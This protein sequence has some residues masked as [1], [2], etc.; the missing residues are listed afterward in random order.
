MMSV[1]QT[2]EDAPLG[3]GDC[4]ENWRGVASSLALLGLAL[5]LPLLNGWKPLQGDEDAYYTFAAHIA[6]QPTDPYGFRFPGDVPANHLLAPPVVL[7]WWALAIRVVGMQPVL[8]K[9]WLI[10]FSLL[11]VFSLHALFRR[12]CRGLEMPLVWFTALSPTL[13]PNFTLMLDVPALALSLAAVSL[14]L[15]AVERGSVSLALVA[16]LL[17]GV[18]ME[19]KYT[20]FVTPVVL[21]LAGLLFRR[22]R[23][24]V[25]AAGLA[26]ALF[27]GWE[28]LTAVRYGESHFLHSL[29]GQSRSL[30]RPLHLLLPLLTMLGGVAPM[31]GL[32]GL[33]GL[34]QSWRV[35]LAGIGVVVCAYLLLVLLRN[36][37]AAGSAG[38]E[39]HRLPIPLVNIGFGVLGITIC[40]VTVL[41][42]CQLLFGACPPKPVDGSGRLDWFIV[43]WL[44]LELAS[45][46]ALTPLPGVRRLLGTVVVATLLAG[47]PVARPGCV[48][49][50]RSLVYGIALANVVLALG[51][52]A[53]EV[54]DARAE[55][56]AVR[57][58]VRLMRQRPVGAAAWFTVDYWSGFDVYAR[59]AGLRRLGGVDE[60]GP[61]AGDWLAVMYR[62]LYHP[63]PSPAP[64]R[65]EHLARVEVRDSLPLRTIPCY[66]CGRAALEHHAGPRALVDIYRLP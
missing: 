22:S 16:G 53:V 12:C 58:T 24:A 25:L 50:R 27:V 31:V 46:F 55:S 43:L 17:T 8:W 42:A 23:L 56:L 35:V 33:A 13:L 40:V 54:R 5:L 65:A 28:V 44:A 30:T 61:H 4:A 3:A 62:P 41:S 59:W 52:L 29:H 6:A 18:A 66:W 7:Y 47:R 14:F 57:R 45:Y 15:R 60:S 26:V 20:A 38:A 39:S 32:L 34:G 21:L 2:S 51:L 36:P 19:T 49:R 10:P 1:C 11:L 48:R 63:Q 9:L 64:A 37:E